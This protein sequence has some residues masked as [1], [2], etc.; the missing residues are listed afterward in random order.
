[1]KKTVY[2]F[3]VLAVIFIFSLPVLVKPFVISLAEKKLS[4]L[5][6]AAEVSIA[7]CSLTPPGRLT[8]LDIEVKE[9]RIRDF[10]IKEIKIEY[11]L[12]SFFKKGFLR[13]FLSA[14]FSGGQVLA[15]LVFRPGKDKRYEGDIKFLNLGLE[16]FTEDFKLGRKVQMSGSLS[17]NAVL[18]GRGRDIDILSGRLIS[19]KGGTLT[20]K[21][22]AFLERIARSSGQSLDILVESF[23]NYHYN[24]G[25]I[26]L[27]LDK[28]DIILDAALDG[29]AGKRDLNIT[30][31]DFE[32][33][34]EGL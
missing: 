2:F 9:S 27:F 17:G 20:I 24:T 19:S 18:K 10:N 7:A 33:K 6:S 4:G 31:H 12:F 1:M 13:V 23:K 21:D 15:D 14:D 29:E 3:L 28:G 34:K 30:V 32:L 16:T 11:N 5:F 8:F 26:K 22:T 25:V